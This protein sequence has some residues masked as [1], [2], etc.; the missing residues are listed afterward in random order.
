[1]TSDCTPLHAPLVLVNVSFGASITLH[2]QADSLQSNI[3][4]TLQR[5]QSDGAMG[6]D[7][8]SSTL[9]DPLPALGY[10]IFVDVLSWVG[11]V[12][13]LTN[14]E[15]VCKGW[16]EVAKSHSS[17]LWRFAAIDLD[18]DDFE[19]QAYDKLAATGQFDVHPSDHR[20][21]ARDVTRLLDVPKPPQDWL[22]PR[23][24][25]RP[26]P[27]A[28]PGIDPCRVN[29]RYVCELLSLAPY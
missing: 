23:S 24:S 26:T 18:I 21:M 7:M 15:K 25:R 19:L 12:Q 11:T 4:A 20:L 22:A 3:E 28:T 8:S 27:L 9:R 17:W 5:S 14:V 10:D 6:D 29:W 1:M 13:D 2:C 16:R